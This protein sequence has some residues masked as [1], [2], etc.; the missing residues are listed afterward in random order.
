MHMREL[1][2]ERIMQKDKRIVPDIHSGPG[3]VSIYTMQTGMIL[4]ARE[5]M[6]LDWLTAQ[7]PA[8]KS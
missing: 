5:E 2:R 3:A 6:V 1:P 8:N 7:D 4:E